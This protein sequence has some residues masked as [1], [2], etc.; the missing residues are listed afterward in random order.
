MLEKLFVGVVD[1][2]RLNILACA[3]KTFLPTLTSFAS[4]TWMALWNA[5]QIVEHFDPC[6]N[7]SFHFTKI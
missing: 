4:C 2:H 6:Y 7:A 1:V 3:S 5:N